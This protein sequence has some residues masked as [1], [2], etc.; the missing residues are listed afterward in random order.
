MFY[1]A[2]LALSLV[3][4]LFVHGAL[5]NTTIDDASSSVTYAPSNGWSVGQSC[6]PCT[7]KPDVKQTTDGTWH[8]TLFLP[9]AN[10]VQT[11]TLKFTGKHVVTCF[12]VYNAHCFLPQ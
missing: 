3:P 7:A 1:W 9:Q 10:V 4:A 11:A 2:I 12:L 8:D 5:V 6:V